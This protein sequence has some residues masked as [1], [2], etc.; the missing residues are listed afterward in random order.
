MVLGV[1]EQFL[2]YYYMGFATERLRHNLSHLK[3][4]FTRTRR[5]E[6]VTGRGEQDE[7]LKETKQNRKET[8]GIYV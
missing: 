7:G 5:Q 6:T 1:K 8:D 4:L 2:L 3:L